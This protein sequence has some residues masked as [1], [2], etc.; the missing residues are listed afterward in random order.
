MREALLA[1][2]WARSL[3]CVLSDVVLPMGIARSGIM[4]ASALGAKQRLHILDAMG[5]YERSRASVDS[6]LS[7]SYC[8]M[9]RASPALLCHRL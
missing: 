2:S 5:R 3:T 8:D 1:F 7:K 4:T 9:V 6:R